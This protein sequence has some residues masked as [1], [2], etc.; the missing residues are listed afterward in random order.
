MYW[1]SFITFVYNCNNSSNITVEIGDFNCF[2]EG[3]GHRWTFGV[4]T[5]FEVAAGAEY[6]VPLE[7]NM[8]DVGV[9]GE[10]GT[11]FIMLTSCRIDCGS[12]E[13]MQFM[14]SGSRY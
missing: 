9:S 4:G 6:D 5:P 11:N 10:K 3:F 8:G 12:G 14:V 1:L 2:D 7:V 13:E